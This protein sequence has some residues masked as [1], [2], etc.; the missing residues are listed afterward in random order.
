[1][2]STNQTSD[3]RQER[4][5]SLRARVGLLAALG[6]GVLVVLVSIAAY[7]TV[8]ASLLQQTDATLLERAYAAAS[9]PLGNRSFLA[10]VPSEAFGAADIHI[11]LLRADGYSI[12]ALDASGNLVEPP[13]GRPERAVARGLLSNSVRTAVGADGKEYRVVAVPS[14]VPGWSLV[15]AQPTAGTQA[16]LRRLGLVLLV[17]GGGGV[18]LAAWAGM[19][20]ARTGLRPVERLT[21]AAEHVARTGDLRPIPVN[22]DDEL[23]RL[24]HAFNAML[25]ALAEARN[26]ERRLIADA[27]HELRTP[28]TSL[29]TNLDLLVQSESDDGP[30]LSPAD[31]SALLQDVRAQVV[32]LSSLVGD[33]V[34]LSREDPPTAA[35]APVDFADIVTHA[36][37]RVRRRAQSL[38]FDLTIEPWTLWGDAQALERAVTN[39]LDN[40]AKWSPPGSVVTVTLR[41]GVLSVADQGPGISEADLPHIFERFYRS[42]EA[43]TM[44]GSGLGLS[45]VKQVAD[46]HGGAV[47]AGR[48]PGGGALFRLWLP[49]SP[50]PRP[51]GN[52]SSPVG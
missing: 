11:V 33:L 24:A 1:M 22:G 51:N 43:R 10:Q 20:I 30:R 15:M 36:A 37:E 50:G 47:S 38:R 4:G 5:L 27:G 52:T 41:D 3:R 44:P 23:A 25:A 7:V 35:H 48:A 21:A 28:L 16:T 42:E 19:A 18:A 6:A 45:I 40:A 31:R 34:E 12:S 9:G 29:R 14:Q 32:E 46:R 49:G 17:V 26:R 13:V 39:L 8:R 2:T